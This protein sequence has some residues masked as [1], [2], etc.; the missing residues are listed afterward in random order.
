[1]KKLNKKDLRLK[2]KP[3]I[4]PG[5][6]KSI[7]RRDKLLRKYIQLKDSIRKNEIH[8]QYKLLRNQIIALIRQSKKNYYQQYFS[9]N[10]K[11][12]KKPGTESKALLILEPTIQTNLHQFLLMKK[13]RLILN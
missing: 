7:K 2:A 10:A 5:I 1:M 3:W 13:L 11:D 9:D 4:T 6:L 12:I 8:T